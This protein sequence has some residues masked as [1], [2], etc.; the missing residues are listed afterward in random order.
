MW[1]STP[2]KFPQA[3]ALHWNLWVRSTASLDRGNGKVIVTDIEH[4]E[5]FATASWYKV[6]CSWTGLKAEVKWGSDCNCGRC[7]GVKTLVSYRQHRIGE[8]GKT[9]FFSWSIP[10]LVAVFL[11][12]L[13]ANLFVFV[14]R[15]VR[16][17]WRPRHFQSEL[18]T[19]S[20]M[21]S[22]PVIAHAHTHAHICNLEVRSK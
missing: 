11:L 19:F 22:G 18:C 6:T 13:F 3:G 15:G 12:H 8:N 7:S 10:A 2:L 20:G 5:Y 4:L 21:E 16:S 1:S 9:L 14:F 17:V